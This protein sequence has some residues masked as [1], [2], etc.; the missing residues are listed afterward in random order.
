M[1]RFEAALARAQAATGLIPEPGRGGPA[2]MPYKHNPVACM[3]AI[4]AAQRTPQRV[5]ALLTAMP[6]E[7]ERALGAWQAELADWPL[8]M[9]STHG[10][11]RALAGALSNL[12][13][14]SQRMRANLDAMRATLP[15]ARADQWFKRGWARHAGEV[16][17]AQLASWTASSV[18]T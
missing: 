10:S 15:K 11:T 18:S 17:L 2:H 5:A 12:R 3:V 8:L 9:M 6:Q 1:L 7:Y 14:D 13:V 4:A 16:A